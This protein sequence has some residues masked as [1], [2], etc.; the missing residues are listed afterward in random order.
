MVRKSYAQDLKTIKTHQ[1]LCL[2]GFFYANTESKLTCPLFSL[3]K[4]S[5]VNNLNLALTGVIGMNFY[6]LK[7]T[8][9]GSRRL[10]GIT[11]PEEDRIGL[12]VKDSYFDSFRDIDSKFDLNLWFSDFEKREFE[13]PGFCT[14]HIWRGNILLDPPLGSKPRG[15]MMVLDASPRNVVS[16]FVLPAHRFYPVT[17]KNM[18]TEE[19]RDYVIL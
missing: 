11:K 3:L 13:D 8:T 1:I 9:L 12:R 10:V 2:M 16:Q 6:E 14:M 4:N 19:K 5:G 7:N 17:I 18:D 15:M